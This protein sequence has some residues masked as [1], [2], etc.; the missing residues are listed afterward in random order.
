MKLNLAKLNIKAAQQKAK[1]DKQ[2][3]KLKLQKP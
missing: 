2:A 1:V 3:L